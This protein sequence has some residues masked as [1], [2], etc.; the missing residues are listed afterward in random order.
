MEQNLRCRDPTRLVGFDFTTIGQNVLIVGK[1]NGEKL[2]IINAFKARTQKPCMNADD[3]T[4]RNKKKRRRDMKVWLGR[5]VATADV[6]DHMN[7]TP[8]N[9]FVWACMN[10]IANCDWV[11][12]CKEDASKMTSC[13][14]GDDRIL[15]PFP[16]SYG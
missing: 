10:D 9:D 3:L 13:E 12:L 14:S 8:P 2:E 5:L 11:D 4:L 7:K 1:K 6:A 15:A 16:Q